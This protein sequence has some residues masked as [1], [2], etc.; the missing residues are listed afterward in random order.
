M[1]SLILDTS[2]RAEI[3]PHPGNNSAVE[4]LSQVSDSLFAPLSKLTTRYS[5][6]P[7]CLFE[8]ALARSRGQGEQGRESRN[9]IKRNIH[10]RVHSLVELHAALTDG[11]TAI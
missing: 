10:F 9:L 11:R 4:F 6:V 7:N 8:V 2:T 1:K 3:C 5:E